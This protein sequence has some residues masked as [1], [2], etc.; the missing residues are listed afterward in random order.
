MSLD[1]QQSL[2][3]CKYEA[4]VR[5]RVSAVQWSDWIPVASRQTEEGDKYNKLA[6]SL[7]KADTGSV[8]VSSC[9]WGAS[10][11]PAVHS[12]WRGG[13]EVQLGGERGG[14]SGYYPP[15]DLPSQPHHCVGPPGCRL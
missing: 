11:C 12:G 6:V 8:L 15:T 4:R 13:G 10:P 2:Q 1:T 14:F 7:C 9:G 5:A 3:G